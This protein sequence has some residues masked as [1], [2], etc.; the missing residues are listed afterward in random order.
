MENVLVNEGLAWETAQ[1]V[2]EGPAEMEIFCYQRSCV[3]WALM[4]REIIIVTI[5]FINN[6]CTHK[7]WPVQS[8]SCEC[9][10][11][12]IILIWFLLSSSCHTLLAITLIIVSVTLLTFLL[13]IFFLFVIFTHCD[14]KLCPM[15]IFPVWT[16]IF[17]LTHWESCIQFCNVTHHAGQGFLLLRTVTWSHGL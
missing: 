7:Y 5:I 6:S 16:V 3:S 17:P 10:L 15:Y 14:L 1:K 4:G 11:W 9:L 2:S 13:Q 12:M 8:K